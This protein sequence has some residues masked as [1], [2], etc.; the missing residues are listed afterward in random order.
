MLRQNG[1]QAIIGI[2]IYDDDFKVLVG[3][4]FKGLEQLVQLG[5]PANRAYDQGNHQFGSLNRK[6]FAV[7]RVGRIL[8]LFIIEKQ[9]QPP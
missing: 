6:I 3:L 1:S 9:L 8:F 7:A 5:G 2:L 4:L